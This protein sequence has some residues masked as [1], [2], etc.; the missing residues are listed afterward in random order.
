MN[1]NSRID[2]RVAALSATLD[3]LDAFTHANGAARDRADAVRGALAVFEERLGERL[4]ELRAGENAADDEAP[5]QSSQAAA[6]ETDGSAAREAFAEF[7][8]Q[9]QRG[10]DLFERPV[11]RSETSATDGD[12]RPVLDE[13]ILFRIPDLTRMPVDFD[14]RLSVSDTIDAVRTAIGEAVDKVAEIEARGASADRSYAALSQQLGAIGTA[15]PDSLDARQAVE[16]ASQTRTRLAGIGIP[17]TESLDQQ[18]RG[19]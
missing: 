17:I 15:T 12:G 14:E 7:Q 6:G 2:E 3:G 18:L 9:V 13:S 16:Q 8:R 5:R 11:V 1:D 19:Y 4:Q 10:A